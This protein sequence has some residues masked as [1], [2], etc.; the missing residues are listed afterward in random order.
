MATVCMPRVGRILA[1]A[2]TFKF[3]RNLESN[4]I[5]EEATLPQICNPRI[6]VPLATKNMSCQKVPGALVLALT[7]SD[8][9]DLY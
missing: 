4:S 8:A 3:T 2:A 1:A 9:R 6:G 5:Q 7:V